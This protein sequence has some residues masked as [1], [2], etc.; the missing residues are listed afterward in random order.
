VNKIETWNIN[1]RRTF[2]PGS[3]SDMNIVRKF[4]HD[5]KW[6]KNCPFYLEW[7]YLDVPSMLK[8]KITKYALKGL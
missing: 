6:E 2:E 1:Q 3:K 8:D 5:N 7:P 4:L